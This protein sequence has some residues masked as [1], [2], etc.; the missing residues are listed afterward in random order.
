MINSQAMNMIM[1]QGTNYY[2]MNCIGGLVGLVFNKQQKL[3]SEW[4]HIL[5]KFLFFSNIFNNLN[6]SPLHFWDS[7]V[8]IYYGLP[9]I[10]DT[11]PGQSMDNQTIYTRIEVKSIIYPVPVCYI[12]SNTACF[13]VYLDLKLILFWL[14]IFA[15]IIVNWDFV[16]KAIIIQSNKL[17]NCKAC[18]LLSNLILL[19]PWTWNINQ[20]SLKKSHCY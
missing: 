5:K 12:Y 10:Q 9:H 14:Q 18:N 16:K 4:L 17:S 3:S 1:W 7:Y 2:C 15:F 6:I 11:C 20:L 8:F 19:L 13:V